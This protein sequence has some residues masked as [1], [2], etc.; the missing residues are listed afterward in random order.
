MRSPPSASIRSLVAFLALAL[1]GASVACGTSAPAEHGETDD[2]LRVGPPSARADAD[3]EGRASVRAG[4]LTLSFEGPLAKEVVDGEPALTLRGKASRNLSSLLSFVPDDAF[5]KA[6]LTGRRTFEIRLQGGH[7]IN[8]I[9]SGMPLRLAV[10][11]TS[12]AAKVYEAALYL[13]GHFESSSTPL[14]VDGS[15]DAVW[16]GV[17]T[18]PLRY[19]TRVVAARTP[20]S[21]SVVGVG[22]A[23]TTLQRSP[24]VFDVDFGFDQLPLVAPAAATFTAA[25]ANAAPLTATATM[26]LRLRAVALTTGELD[27]AFPEKCEATVRRC[28]ARKGAETDLGECG[29]Y[30]A[31]ERCKDEPP[32]PDPGE[33]AVAARIAAAVRTATGVAFNPAVLSTR[34]DGQRTVVQVSVGNGAAEFALGAAVELIAITDRPRF[35]DEWTVN[36]FERQLGGLGLAGGRIKAHG[37]PNGM[38]PVWQLVVDNVAGRSTVAIQ[39]TSESTSVRIPWAYDEGAFRQLAPALVVESALGLAAQAGLWAELEVY[40]RSVERFASASGL[41]AMTTSTSPVGFNPSTEV[42]L[43]ASSIWGDNA[44]YVTMNRATGAVRVDNFN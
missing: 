16:S 40:L 42:Q 1:G 32:P 43:G 2:E 19:R 9:L 6:T 4:V 11:T 35:T 36:R 15:I 44:F 14:R 3:A 33:A 12:G 38:A 21:L 34:V 5:G 13:G 23:A 20:A 30:R 28:L 24:R 29:S 27:T 26:D 39:A 10:Q 18:D 31:V 8:T 37:S 22:G 25:F 41:E 7:E 17:A